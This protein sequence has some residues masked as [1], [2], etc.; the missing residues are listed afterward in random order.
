[1]NYPNCSNYKDTQDFETAMDLLIDMDFDYEEDLDFN[2]SGYTD[3][4]TMTCTSEDYDED[5]DR[6]I[7]VD[8]AATY[9]IDTHSFEP[10]F[11]ASACATNRNSN[12]AWP[13]FSHLRNSSLGSIFGG[14]S[15]PPEVP[16]GINSTSSSSTSDYLDNEFTSQNCCDDP[17]LYHPIEEVPLP[18]PISI[19]FGLRR[20]SSCSSDDN[21]RKDRKQSQSPNLV[22]ELN[23]N[24]FHVS[25]PVSPTQ[26][27]GKFSSQTQHPLAKKVKSGLRSFKRI[28][29]G[30]SKKIWHASNLS[31]PNTEDDMSAPLAKTGDKRCRRK[32]PAK[33]EYVTL[34]DFDVLLGRGGLSNGHPGNIMYR[35]HILRRQKEYKM[36]ENSEK[37]Q[38]S[39][40]VVAWVKTRGGRFLKRDDEAPGQPFYIATDVTARQ[41]VSQALREDHTPEGRKQ[42]KSR[43]KAPQS[44]GMTVVS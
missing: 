2:D 19:H 5:I 35:K 43:T 39:K 26:R 31:V 34:T 18:P 22:G 25:P 16:L 30:T 33:K 6:M 40:D 13:T 15:C 29:A 7:D 21:K 10:P 3:A 38:M 42:K 12:R 11:L 32:E 41:K 37:T 14:T 24:T 27:E 9:L 20:F 28:A 23:F 17:L 44:R 8:N 36:L 1:M 4:T